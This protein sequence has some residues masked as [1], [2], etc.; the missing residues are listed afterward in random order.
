MHGRTDALGNDPDG[1]SMR[2]EVFLG[3]GSNLEDPRMQLRVAIETLQ[4]HL[5]D[6][7]V[8]PWYQSKP[9][10]PEGQPDYLNTVVC[11][12]TELE[13]DNL[14]DLCQSIETA[15]GRVRSERWGARTLDIDVLYFGDARIQTPRLQIPHPEILHRAF[16][17]FPL[18]DLIPT[19]VTPTGDHL[20]RR[21]YDPTSLTRIDSQ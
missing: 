4:Q 16:V 9:L 5:T 10:G 18:L 13:P 2:T 15:Q 17:V 12:I 20:D 3:L 21:R 1:R 14:L 6:L 11:G 8:A 7:K 19:A